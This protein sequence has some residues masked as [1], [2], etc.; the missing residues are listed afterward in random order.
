MMK[1]K[2]LI[3][4]ITENF[5]SIPKLIHKKLLKDEQYCIGQDISPLQFKLL[6]LLNEETDM[7]SV[8]EISNKL[9]VSKPNMTHLIDNLINYGLAERKP[10]TVDRRVINIYI[11]SKGRQYVDKQKKRIISSL[12]LAFDNLSNEDLQVLSDAL[13]KMKMVL[14]KLQ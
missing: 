4:K 7:M 14:S 1:D 3:I 6:F 9:A 5:L 11:T 13:I 10:S 8:S 2:E 12:Q